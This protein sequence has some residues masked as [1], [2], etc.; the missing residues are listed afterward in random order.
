MMPR[1]RE[2]GFVPRAT[3]RG[4]GLFEVLAALVIASLALGVMAA[5]AGTALRAERRAARTIEAVARARSHLAMALEDTAPVP[6]EQEG[7][8]GSGFQWHVRVVTLAQTPPP[9]GTALFGVT[10]W[11]SWSEG[12]G[13]AE[14]RLQSERLGHMP[15]TS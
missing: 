11:I 3:M 2:P 6:G 13:N 4:F 15:G 10:V 7:D 9:K 5:S 14:V 12:S 1:F 8:D